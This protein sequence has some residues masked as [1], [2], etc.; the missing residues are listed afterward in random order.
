MSIY[1]VAMIAEFIEEQVSNIDHNQLTKCGTLTAY[2]RGGALMKTILVVDDDV[3]I[4]QTLSMILKGCGYHVLG[5]SNYLDAEKQFSG[6]AVDLVILDH[7]LP[8]LTGS[9]LAKQFKEIKNVLILMLTGNAELLAKPDAVDVLLPKPSN[10][11]SLLAEIDGLFA[12]A[13]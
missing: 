8:G 10:V 11:P 3:I 9:A 5:A 4:L 7:G 1:G 12:R 13:A 2:V 6:N